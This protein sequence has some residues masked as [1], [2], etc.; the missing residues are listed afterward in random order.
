M[1]ESIT[2]DCRPQFSSALRLASY[3]RGLKKNKSKALVP[4]A[5][6]CARGSLVGCDDGGGVEI[7]STRLPSFKYYN[8]IRKHTEEQESTGRSKTVKPSTLLQLWISRLR[9]KDQRE[10]RK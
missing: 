7:L 5:N 2:C 10:S 3:R 1:L 8:Y 6:F 4:V 9:G